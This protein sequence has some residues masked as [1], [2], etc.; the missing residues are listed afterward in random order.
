MFIYAN[1]LSLAFVRVFLFVLLF[2]FNIVVVF[3]FSLLLFDLNVLFF[4]SFSP[5]YTLPNRKINDCTKPIT[6]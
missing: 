1:I 5:I 4:V 2:F 6:I 3:L